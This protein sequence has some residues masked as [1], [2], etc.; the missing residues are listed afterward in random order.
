MGQQ[1]K[2]EGLNKLN[3]ASKKNIL[4]KAKKKPGRKPLPVAEVS[5]ERVTLL[6]T[7][8]E[9]KRLRDK[10]PQSRATYPDSTFLR[11]YLFENTD[12]FK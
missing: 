3:L 12:L 6:L 9:L 5:S 10:K 4:P 2:K 8:E 1:L 7:P 11:D